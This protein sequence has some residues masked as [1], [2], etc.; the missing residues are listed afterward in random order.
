M[1][2]SLD[3]ALSADAALVVGNSLVLSPL[4][5]SQDGFKLLMTGPGGVYTV[6]ASLDFFSWTSLGTT[7]VPPGAVVFTDATTSGFARKYY[8]VLVQ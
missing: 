1:S 6:M 5:F 4:G 2:N 8:R 3:S 7:N